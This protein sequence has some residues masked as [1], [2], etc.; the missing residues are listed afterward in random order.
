[1]WGWDACVALGGRRRRSRDEGDAS[2][3]TTP[4]PTP[5]PTEQRGFFLLNLTPIGDHGDRPYY[6]RLLLHDREQMGT[7]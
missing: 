5:A 4:S 1:M 6:G 3:P 2:V 7:F